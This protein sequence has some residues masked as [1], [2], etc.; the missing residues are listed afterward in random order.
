M[1]ASLMANAAIDTIVK[2]KEKGLLCKLDIE[3]AYD[4]IN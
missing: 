3:K 2:R 1:D 4:Q